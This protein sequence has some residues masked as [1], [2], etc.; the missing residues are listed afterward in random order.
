M[1]APGKREELH[2]MARRIAT[3]GY[4]VA[5]PN[6]YYRKT[7][8]FRLARDEDGYKRMFAMMEHLS[9]ELVMRDTQAM[10][11]FVDGHPEANAS[12]L[13]A[14]GYCMSGPWVFAAAA[15][16]PEHVRCAASIYGVR[17]ATDNADSPHL[18]AHKVRGELYFACAETD[19]YAPKEMVNRLEA[20]LHDTPGLRHRVEWY[21][22]VEHGFAFPQRQ[23]IYHKPSAER[24]WERL[25]ALF[26]RNLA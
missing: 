4:F 13:G 22:G 20:H 16:F 23:G 8:E 19:K 17:L 6:L 1:D 2:D 3:A 7:R 18:Q 5:L 9:S 12:A 26:K 14:V 24:H 21:M 11:D 25:F 15:R 10:L